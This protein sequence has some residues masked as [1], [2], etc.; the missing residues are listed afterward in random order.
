MRQRALLAAAADADRRVRLLRALR[1]VAGVLELVV[2][3]VEGRGLL[4]EQ[5]G[6]H[7]AGLLEAVEALL[8]AA[9]L[10]AVGAGLLLV[11]AGADAELEPA[12]GD[13]VERRGHVGQHGGMPVVDA[14]DQHADAQPLGGLR[15]R[16]QRD[17][18]LQARPGGVG[19]DRIEV[20][21]RPAGLEDVDVVGRLPD[22]SISAQ[23]VFCGEV[24]KANRTRPKTSRRVR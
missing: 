4:G 12:V 6:Q 23:V 5:A 2:L 24:L 10:D 16:G 20:V 9:E 15:Q 11:P 22:G 7:L 17:P 19:E 1:L 8:D 14:G 13:D 3:A 18:A 21:E